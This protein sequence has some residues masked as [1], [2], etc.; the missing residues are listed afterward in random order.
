M[1]LNKRK[2][3][4]IAELVIVIAVI[5][6]LVM[7]L[8]PG[9]I[10][11]TRDS[12]A[13]QAANNAYTNYLIE[14]ND[15]MVEYMLYD[16]DGRWVALH[17]GVAVGVYENKED[18]LK[19]MIGDNA[20]P[21]KLIVNGM[22]LVYSEE[23]VK[24]NLVEENIKDNTGEASANDNLV[25]ENT[26][27]NHGEDS[28]KDNPG[29]ENV[30]DNLAGKKIS[31]MGDS[32]S[33]FEG[34][35][36]NSVYNY[37]LGDNRVYYGSSASHVY[38]NLI[39]VSDTWWM[40]TVNKLRL[41]FY[42]NNS[43]SGSRVTSGGTHPNET[44]SG[45]RAMNL[46]NSED[47]DIIVIYMGTNDYQEQVSLVAFARDYAKMVEK[48]KKRYPNADIYLC[49]LHNYDYVTAG[50]SIAPSSYNEKIKSIAATYDCNIVDFYNGTGVTPDNIEYYT[51]D[52]LIDKNDRSL[53]HPN[54][55]G[56]GK[57]YE[58]L[59][60]AL[61]KNYKIQEA[62]KKSYTVTLN[63]DK[64][65]I[66]GKY[67][68]V[69]TEGNVFEVALASN[70]ATFTVTMGGNRIDCYDRKNGKVI[71]PYVT[72]NIVITATP[73]EWVQYL[74]K[75]PSK[76]DSTTNLYAEDLITRQGFY[77]LSN[78][79]VERTDLIAAIFPVSEGM[80]LQSSSFVHVSGANKGTVISWFM[81]DG[82]QRG[83][84]AEYVYEQQTN[85]GYVVVPEGAVAVCMVWRKNCTT[86]ACASNYM[87]I[88][89]PN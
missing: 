61:A 28:T 79:W 22:L 10:E 9:L 8:V 53:V 19:E 46:H 77:D 5:V 74:N 60:K 59:K 83:V 24:D 36:N 45:D 34:W 14:N 18:A 7:V 32:I 73:F 16:A 29:E 1:K 20:D 57:M 85:N 75:L 4:T 37:T 51:V 65:V 62:S 47:P 27:D 33:T 58:C 55:S 49:T 82:T 13:I 56:M 44:G 11:N 3:F 48:I 81:A 25:E 15:T 12:K 40:K 50:K 31:F 67:S 63:S 64:S 71:I 78:K 52:L 69:V 26:K 2:A 23:S 30:K 87:Y 66:V 89:M 80:R 41:D 17:N 39:S 88:T 21:S 84:K 35:S 6:I 38:Q 72:G 70:M 54:A 76:F 86:D 43:Y 68:S 42:V